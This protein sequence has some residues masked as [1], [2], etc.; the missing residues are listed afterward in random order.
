[1]TGIVAA[2]AYVPRTR[3]PLALIQ[4]RKPKDDGPE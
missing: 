1:M 4:G 3:L 2:G